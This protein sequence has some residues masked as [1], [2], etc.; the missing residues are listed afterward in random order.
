MVSFD[1]K[2]AYNGVCKE[3]LTERLRSRGIPTKLV[4]WIKAFCSNRS[5]TV[6]VNGQVSTR[7]ALQQAGLPQGSPLSPILFLFFNAD[8]VQRQIDKNGGAIAFVD[9]YTAWVTGTSA[10]SNRQGIQDIVNEATSWERRSGATFEEDKTAFIHF[11]RSPARIDNTPVTVKGKQ[12]G[13][14][15]STKVL[16]VVM[17]SA[18]RYKQHVASAVTR[19]LKAAMAPERLRG[20]SPRIA[21]RLSEATVT[22][23]VDYISSVSMHTCNT[24]KAAFNRVQRIGAQAIIGCFRTVSTVIAEA[25]ASVRTVQER[26]STRAA[27]LWINTRTLPQSNPLTRLN[28][29]RKVRRF[30]SPLQRIATLY[31]N[32]TMDRLEDIGPYALAP[33]KPRPKASIEP[34]A[35]KALGMAV[36]TIGI[37]IVVSSSAR[38]EIVGTGI[39]I[40]DTEAILYNGEARSFSTTLGPRTEQNLYVASLAAISEGLLWLIPQPHTRHIHI[41][42]SDRG[43]LQAISRPNQQSGQAAMIQICQEIDYLRGRGNVV[44]LEWMP[45]SQDFEPGEKAKAAAR[46]A[47]EKDQLPR[48]Q[49]P[50]T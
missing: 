47:T 50:T 24:A 19:G 13:P 29:K 46:K 3:R 41:L 14:V 8:L 10:S 42:S 31:H 35:A 2:G 28:M 40:Q 38:N 18:L 44:S 48:S 27:K 4:S 6:T 16:G 9:D 1:V 11:T 34:D 30:V 32:A 5:A 37:R 26:H 21:R 17:E 23:T 39:T 12:I 22:P 49:R 7:I 36:A 20:L 15:D 25:E 33:W 43:A 45:S